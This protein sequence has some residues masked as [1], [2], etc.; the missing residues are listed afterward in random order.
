MATLVIA[1][2]QAREDPPSVSCV[3]DKTEAQTRPRKEA[4]FLL[5]SR[6][7]EAF[8]SQR[9]APPDLPPE[10]NTRL[11]KKGRV[12]I[13]ERLPALQHPLP[14]SLPPSWVCFSASE[15]NE[16]EAPAATDVP[17]RAARK[18]CASPALSGP[19]LF[20]ISEVR[21]LI[22]SPRPARRVCRRNEFIKADRSNLLQ[23]RSIWLPDRQ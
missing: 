1:L 23:Q 12:L 2:G 18:L 17:E 8:S 4:D 9:S 22:N 21:S 5:F 3:A 13:L 11:I 15:R 16:R 6:E 7:F 20:T 19:S 14:P 10:E